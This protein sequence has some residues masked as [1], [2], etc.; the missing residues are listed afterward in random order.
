[1]G[2]SAREYGVPKRAGCA[3]GV[4]VGVRD[5]ALPAKIQTVPLPANQP[6]AEYPAKQVKLPVQTR[7]AD[8]LAGFRSASP[9]HKRKRT[10]GRCAGC[11]GLFARLGGRAA[12]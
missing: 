1:M 8:A 11:Q 10:P 4:G 9:L 6:P 7:R 2:R 5:L 3:I 12:L